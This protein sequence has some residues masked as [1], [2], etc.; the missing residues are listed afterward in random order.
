M[1]ASKMTG[2]GF[3][4]GKITSCAVQVARVSVKVPI[5]N[6]QVLL[7]GDAERKESRQLGD[8]LS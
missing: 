3:R 5:L 7:T 4:C 6:P 8:V 1:A 2:E